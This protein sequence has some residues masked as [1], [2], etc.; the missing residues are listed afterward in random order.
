MISRSIVVISLQ[1]EQGSFDTSLKW[2]AVMFGEKESLVPTV[3]GYH[4]WFDLCIL[5][6][7]VTVCGF[8]E[9]R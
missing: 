8:I 7:S 1:L 4:D 2:D 3:T 9:G 6:L 5:C